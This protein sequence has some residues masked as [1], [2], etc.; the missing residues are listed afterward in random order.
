MCLCEIDASNNNWR[1]RVGSG[2]FIIADFL[3]AREL[4]AGCVVKVFRIIADSSIAELKQV[5]GSQIRRR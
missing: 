5:C 3:A 4:P 2:T 1:E